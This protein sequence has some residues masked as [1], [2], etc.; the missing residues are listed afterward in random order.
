MPA[1]LTPQHL[2]PFEEFILAPARTPERLLNDLVDLLAAGVSLDSRAWQQL[3]IY[4]PQDEIEQRFL[5]RT[6]GRC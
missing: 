1:K 6:D 4:A 2:Q 3:L 5:R